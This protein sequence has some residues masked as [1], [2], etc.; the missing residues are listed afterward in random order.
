MK[1]KSIN[2]FTANAVPAIIFAALGAALPNPAES[3]PGGTD[4]TALGRGR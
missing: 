1:R 3:L 4:K 2:P